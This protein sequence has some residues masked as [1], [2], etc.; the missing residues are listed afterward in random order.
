[1]KII[2]LF[3]SASSQ[4]VQLDGK[5]IVFTLYYSSEFDRW[6]AD[7]ENEDSGEK[8]FSI[9]LNEGEDVLTASGRIGLEALVPVS[10]PER[11]FE[12]DFENF[13]N[14]VIMVYMT[15]DEY[16][17]ARYDGDA[18]LRLLWKE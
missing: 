14:K 9:V 3:K 2:S 17:L 15:I 11:G 7:I 16:N 18:V 6:L 13:L 12:A 1:M 8:V 4:R 5:S 10:V